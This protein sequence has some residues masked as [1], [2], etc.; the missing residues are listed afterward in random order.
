M[1][2]FI[3]YLTKL[4]GK[5]FLPPKEYH[6]Y[7]D[8]LNNNANTPKDII[9]MAYFAY[10]ADLMSRIAYVLGKKTDAKKYEKLFIN[11]KNAFNKK[12]VDKN[13]IIKG[14]TQTCYILALAYNLLDNEGEKHAAKYLVE[15]IEERNFHLSTGFVGTKDIMTVL[16][17]IGRNDVAYKLLLNTTFPSW[18]FSIKNGATTIW[19]RWNG[20][21]PDQGFGNAAMNSY[22]HYAY[23]AVYLWMAENIGGIRPAE[24]AFK[25]IIIKPSP[26]GNLENA[27]CEY[28]SINGKISTDWSIN[29]AA[30][31][32]NVE[33][34]VNTTAKI[35]VPVGEKSDVKENGIKA[36]KVKKLKFIGMEKEYA[37]FET[38]SGKYSFTST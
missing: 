16:E 5:N 11:I 27:K 20:W 37:V 26:G 35:Y 38:G 34:P 18:G 8:W 21:T 32:L 28:E 1:T 24:I 14:D 13:Y 36:V 2:R 19:E 29:K 23:G 4:S 15:R 9:Y 6:C 12:Y 31:K 17:K 22:A 3:N 33:I 25:K 10:S 30:F 7:G